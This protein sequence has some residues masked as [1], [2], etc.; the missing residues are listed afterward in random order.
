MSTM[1]G[2]YLKLLR[3]RSGELLKDMADDLSMS[4][5]MLSSVENGKRSIPKDFVEKVT[6]AYSLLP[7]QVEELRFAI[8]QTKEE[9]AMSLKGLSN[10]DQELAF[11]FARKFSELDDDSK[12]SLQELLNGGGAKR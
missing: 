2:R 11:S 4:P 10:E 8:A 5:A 12:R 9:V 1:L 3:S 6:A 7:E